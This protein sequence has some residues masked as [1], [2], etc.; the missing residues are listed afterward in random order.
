MS[1]IIFVSWSSNAQGTTT[2]RAKL[3]Y[4]LSW[5]MQHPEIVNIF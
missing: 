3:L 4:Y 1:K 2:P 5:K